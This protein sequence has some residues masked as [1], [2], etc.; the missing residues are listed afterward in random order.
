MQRVD[1]GA[2]YVKAWC[3]QLVT[4]TKPSN[5]LLCASAGTGEG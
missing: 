2:A 1:C 3:L 5:M 4:V